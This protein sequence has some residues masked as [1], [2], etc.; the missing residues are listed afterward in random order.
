MRVLVLRNLFLRL[1]KLLSL[2]DSFV[3]DSLPY[4]PGLCLFSRLPLSPMI[5]IKGVDR[6]HKKVAF[7][8]ELL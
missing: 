5:N 6:R 4:R 2:L 8:L 7:P 3:H 1:A